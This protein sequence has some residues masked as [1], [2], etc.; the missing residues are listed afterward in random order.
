MY[1]IKRRYN[2]LLYAVVVMV[3]SSNSIAAQS[4]FKSFFKLSCPEKKW[5]VSHPFVAKKALNISKNVRI[6]TDSIASLKLLK[7]DGNGDQVDAFRHTL[8]MSMLSNSIGEKK[9]RKLGIA[10]EK[11]NYKQFKK[12]KLED[13]NVPDSVSSEMDLFNNEV[14]I[15][16]SKQ[17]STHLVQDVISAVLNGRCKIIKR[18]ANGTFL[19]ENN[20]AIDLESIKGKWK[21]E[22]CLVWSD[23]IN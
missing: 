1:L 18:N 19:D 16:L 9:S 8:W 6:Q 21:N 13:G 22:K 10:H 15:L 4:A 23:E 11:G 20:D 14:G 12:S 5:V 2:K 7:G 3:L 17:N